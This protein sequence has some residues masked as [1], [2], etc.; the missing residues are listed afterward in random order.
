MR[1]ESWGARYLQGDG[2]HFAADK[3]WRRDKW[4]ALSGG[5]FAVAMRTGT[6]AMLITIPLKGGAAK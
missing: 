3:Y 5:G 1:F 6:K 2:D 4:G